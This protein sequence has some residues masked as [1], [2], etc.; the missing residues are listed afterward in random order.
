MAGHSGTTLSPALPSVTAGNTIIALANVANAISNCTTNQSNAASLGSQYT[1]WTGNVSATSAFSN[2]ASWTITTTSTV[3]FANSTAATSFFNAGGLIQVAF[4][5]SSTGATADTTWNTFVGAGAASA[6]TAGVIYLSGTPT[7]KT[8]SGNAYTG[9]TKIG[10]SGTA[11]VLA[12]GT[13]YANLTSTTTTLFKQFLT[14][15]GYA[16]SYV[17]VQANVVSS[18]LN[19]VT[20]WYDAS[21]NNLSGGT[22]TSGITY[23]TAPAT[24]VTYFPPETTYLTNVWGT[25][26]IASSVTTS[27]TAPVVATGDPLFNYTTLLTAPT[28][29]NA[30]NNNTIVDLSSNAFTVTRV[31]QPAQG[32]VSPVPLTGGSWSNYFNGSSWL[33]T[34]SS[35]GA[36]F[37]IGTG[38]FTV[39]AWIYMPQFSGSN[40]YMAVF[41]GQSTGAPWFQI[42]NGNTINVSIN[43]GGTPVSVS[44][45]FSLNTWYHV[46]W[47]RT[48]S[49][50]Q[51]F[52]NGVQAGSVA[53]TT[54]YSTP[55]GAVQVGASNSGGTFVGYISNLRVLVG[56]GL[57][58][59]SFVVPT[60]PLTAITN[61]KLLTC[62]SNYFADNSAN[63]FAMTMN[64]NPT[65]SAFQPFLTSASYS[66][67]NGNSFYLDGSSYLTI[68]SSSAFAYGTGDFSLES[69]LYAISSQRL[70]WHTDDNFNMDLNAG[71]T[72][73]A[74]QFFSG[75]TGYVTTPYV[76]NANTWNHLLI[77]RQSGQLRMFINGQ[78]CYNTSF[79]NSHGSSGVNIGLYGTSLPATQGWF[80]N[81][82]IVKGGVPTAYSTSSTTN[83]TQIFTPSTTPFT[84]SESL[85]GGSVSLLLASRT[86]GIADQTVNTNLITYGSAQVNTAFSP[87]N[88]P[89]SASGG[90]VYLNGTNSNLYVAPSSAFNLYSSNW[91]IEA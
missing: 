14:A 48:S 57:Y 38:N 63:T 9:T 52:V 70:I 91:T 60:A 61:T 67:S 17:Q 35:A 6:G 23:G 30:A 29:T 1:A 72:S 79:T 34:S 46:A 18:T 21:G 12:T 22:A 45:T 87:F 33:L 15:T 73:G 47:S 16:N 78:L 89:M 58:T 80:Y 84:G 42:N 27:N 11:N 5:K 83:G 49:V 56:T 76:Y 36:S 69:W 51:I 41:S 3:T 40:T 82:R 37:N 59:S 2:V 66:V 43:G 8:I 32:S 19:L 26:S 90:G 25:P 28:G 50:T 86:A 62:Q 53:D 24:T 65:V 20:T 10:G 55:T 4:N 85:T 64:G 31:G 81:L 75:G 88:V 68:P 54:N 74:L 39:E 13:G 44:Y 7:S 71:T 77:T